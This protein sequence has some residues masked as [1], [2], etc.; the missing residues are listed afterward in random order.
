LSYSFRDVPAPEILH[1]GSG[2][3]FAR[4]DPWLATRIPS[5]IAVKLDPDA[6]VHPSVHPDHIVCLE[7]GA[8]VK[9]L[10]THII[11]RFHLTVDQYL[12]RWKLPLDY[13]V[14]APSYSARK[15]ALAARVG[16]GRHGRS[17]HPIVSGD[18]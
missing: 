2:P 4:L 15:R 1:S 9:V 6:A 8:C 17:S 18:R 14:V 16:L 7:D 11:R 5:E 3:E 12:A 10:R 13:P